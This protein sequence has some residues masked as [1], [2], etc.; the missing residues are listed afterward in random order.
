DR[1]YLQQLDGNLGESLDSIQLAQCLKV[2][3][4]M[5]Q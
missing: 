1:V 3:L 5:K 4:Q 2:N